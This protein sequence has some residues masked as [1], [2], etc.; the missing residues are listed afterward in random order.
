MTFSDLMFYENGDKI[1]SFLGRRGM[2]S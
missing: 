2:Q 1:R